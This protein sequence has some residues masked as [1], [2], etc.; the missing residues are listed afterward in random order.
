[1]QQDRLVAIAHFNSGTLVKQ[2]AMN[3]EPPATSRGSILIVDDVPNNLVLLSRLLTQKGYSVRAVKSGKLA[4]E[5]VEIAAPELILMDICMPEMDGY[6]VCQKLKNSDH[7][8]DIPIIFISALDEVLDKIKAF[9]AGGVDY[10]T[11]PFQL[12]EVLARVETHLTLQRLRQELQLQNA[13]LHHEIAERQ[14][15]E[16]KY[17][18]IFENCLEGIFQITPDGGYLSANP[19]LAKIYGYRS[20]EDLMDSVTDIRNL[21]VRP[22]RREELNAY[23][24]RYGEVEDFESQAYRRDNQIIWISENV[25]AVRDAD[26]GV[27]YYEGTVQD[28]T[29]RRQ[30]EAELRV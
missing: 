12:A 10:I 1:M 17:R 6:A 4:L 23:L 29:E 8:R 26:G 9:A 30:T 20:P 11:K 21:Y 18:S 3:S 19:A 15:A 13:R 7:T 25:R 5:A 22:G 28:I 16:D 27:L 24:R 2:L 14:K